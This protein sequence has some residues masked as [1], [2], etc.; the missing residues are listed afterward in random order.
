MC[1]RSFY[2]FIIFLS[3]TICPIDFWSQY[4]IIFLIKKNYVYIIFF[5]LFV[6]YFIIKVILSTIWQFVY[7]CL[8][9]RVVKCWSTTWLLVF[10]FSLGLLKNTESIDVEKCPWSNLSLVLWIGTDYGVGLVG[11]KQSSVSWLT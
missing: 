2:Y 6:T 11:A 8:L 5:V 1:L 9:R 10:A 4:L 7:W 3:Q